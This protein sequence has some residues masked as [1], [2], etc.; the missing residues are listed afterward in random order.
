MRGVVGLVFF[1]AVS[2]LLAG[3][4]SDLARAI[5]ESS[6]DADSC[7]RV[8]DLTV[9][10]E[11]IRIYLTDGYLIFTK[12]VTGRPIAAVFTTEVEGGDGE[13][14][15]RPPNQAERRSLAS[16][17]GSPNL[18][19]HF[20]SALFVFTD[21]TYQTLTAQLAGNPA[22]RK[23]P[24]MGLLLERTWTAAW[25]NVA[26]G[27]EARLLL[28]L[29]NTGWRKPNFFSAIFR[30]AKL[31]DFDVTYDPENPDQIA[32][33]QFAERDK[34]AFFD[35]WTHFPARS[36]RGGATFPRLKLDLSDYRIEATLEPDLNLAAVTH[37][38]LKT[39]ADNLRAIPFEL[40][41]EM[42]VSEVKVNGEPA[43][44]VQ[45][46]IVRTPGGR[47]ENGAFLVVPGAPLRA[48][49]QY[50]LEFHHAGKVVLQAA[51]GIYYVT[52]RGNWYPSIGLRFS[53]FDLTFRY[54]RDLELVTAGDVVE[55]RT[56]G[57]W[58]ITRRRPSNPIR[59]AGFNLGNYARASETRGAYTVDVYANRALE[60]ALQPRPVVS[61][62]AIAPGTRRAT[63][64]TMPE[65]V[66]PPA[67]DPLGRLKLLA[68]DV[69]ATLEF[70]GAKFGPPALS[71]LTV[72]PIPGNFGQ[73]YP[74]L[75]YLSTRSYVDAQDPRNEL[76]YDELLQAHE[77]AHQWWGG[78]V[79]SASYRDDWLMEALANY[80]ALLYLERTKG[81]AHVQALMEGY[82]AE[83][84]AKRDTGEPV[85]SAGPIVMGTRL[86]SS[87]EPRAWRAITYG[88]GSWI[89]HM[90][91][92]RMGDERF[93]S[94]LA[95]IVKRYS[96]KEIT[97]EE[98]RKLAS[99]FLP[100]KSDDPQLEAFFDQWVYGTGIPSLKLTYTLKGKAP[101]YR[102]VGT[103]TQNEVPAD[104]SA[105][106]P[107][108]IQ[109]MRGKTITQWV[110]TADEPV[111]F[112]VAVTQPPVKVL[113]DPHNAVLRR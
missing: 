11:D 23:V 61:L 58:R 28:E 108:E 63:R 84:L 16:Y 55:D 25:R 42:A 14:M 98:F 50:E 38:K 30:T 103:V 9:I 109:V 24:E 93:L 2:P 26:S 41:G 99:G 68:A 106:V 88:K 54:P 104:F 79:V 29:M 77:T 51:K 96:G 8:R 90:L 59:V 57:E 4:G 21:D 40:A 18:D 34:R 85:D 87:L 49:Q 70:M 1:W 112:S 82:R 44:V 52:A 43:E 66:N 72:S 75:I 19:E 100:P 92:Q 31:G 47:S 15:L 67:L 45:R 113:L 89:L 110:H 71:H 32:A 3:P 64:P 78:Q 10:K 35:L 94:L 13:V 95:E 69:G 33:G 48:G 107:V 7:F 37:V 65:I 86:E 56:E 91:R 60:P 73:G 39:D 27:Y 36:M 101:S 74:G 111:T 53:N 83:L 80:S 102:L 81:E 22:N 5:R 76:F 20:Q 17:T 97:T 105:L 6:L 62:P 12:P 46:E